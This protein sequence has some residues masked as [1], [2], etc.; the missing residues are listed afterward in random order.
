[1]RRYRSLVRAGSRTYPL[2]W[3]MF[4]CLILYLVFRRSLYSRSL[5]LLIF[6]FLYLYFMGKGYL[7]PFFARATMLLFPGFCILAG[8]ACNDLLSRFKNKPTVTLVLAGALLLVVGPS[9]LFDVAY[10]CAMRHKDTRL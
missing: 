9:V 10:A 2:L 8:L 5:P 4:Y 6:S 3:V 7:G 1:M